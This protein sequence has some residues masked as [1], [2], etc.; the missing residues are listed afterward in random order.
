M[1]HE[2]NDA[3]IDAMR[4]ELKD[5]SL[6]ITQSIQDVEDATRN[7]RNAFRLI[8]SD[9]ATIQDNFD[10]LPLAHQREDW[11]L[12][13]NLLTKVRKTVYSFAYLEGEAYE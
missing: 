12:I 8:A 3:I 13:N 7:A 6:S 10:E 9:L 4:D 11:Q 5:I 1:S 2:G